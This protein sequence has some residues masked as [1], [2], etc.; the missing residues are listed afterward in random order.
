MNRARYLSLARSKYLGGLAR[1]EPAVWREIP[2]LIATK[3]PASYDRAVG[4][5]VDLRDA[6]A[7]HGREAGFLA[8]L[9]LLRTEHARKTSFISRIWSSGL[10]W[11]AKDR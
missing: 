2:E 5:L 6:A 3:R 10:R 9:D 8:Q 4:L 7:T 1:K 11:P